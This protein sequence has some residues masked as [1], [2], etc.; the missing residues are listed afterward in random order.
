MFFVLHVLLHVHV[1]VTHGL[2]YMYH[3]IALLVCI[4]LHAN[5]SPSAS[6]HIM[7]EIISI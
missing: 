7:D 5:C 4:F 1:H 3:V 2:L 6:N